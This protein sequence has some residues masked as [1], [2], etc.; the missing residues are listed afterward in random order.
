MV[1]SYPLF[2]QRAPWSVLTWWL[3][4]L[5]QGCP[6]VTGSLKLCRPLLL[7]SISKGLGHFHCTLVI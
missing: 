4:G 5:F 6:A 7:R 3:L 2:H 1:G